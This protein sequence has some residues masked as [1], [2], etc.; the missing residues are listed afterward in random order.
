MLQTVEVC[1]HETAGPG[2][3]QNIIHRIDKF[4][5]TK[6]HEAS[7]AMVVGLGGDVIASRVL[8]TVLGMSRYLG[9]TDSQSELSLIHI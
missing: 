1:R 3:L 2:T 6:V 4:T 5:I 7:L 9:H 8:C